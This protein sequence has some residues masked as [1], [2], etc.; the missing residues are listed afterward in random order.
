MASIMTRPNGHRWIFFNSPSGKRQT[1]RLGGASVVQ[2]ETFKLR[3]EK[4]TV[5]ARLGDVRRIVTGLQPAESADTKVSQTRKGPCALPA[6]AISSKG[7]RSTRLRP[8]WAIHQPS[9]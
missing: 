6:S 7:T 9:R 2:A 5:A 4:L 1:I 8:G 3:I